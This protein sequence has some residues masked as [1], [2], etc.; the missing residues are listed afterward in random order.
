LPRKLS[1]APDGTFPCTILEATT[2]PAW[3]CDP[4]MNRREPDPSLIQPA[5][6]R[7]EADKWCNSGANTCLP[8]CNAF[9]FCEIMPADDTCLNVTPRQESIG[10]CYVDQRE[11][12]RSCARREVP[13]E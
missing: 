10:W 5:R 13:G 12:R 2:D 11:P 8:D 7:L 3:S 4:A 1:V 6:Q 9:H